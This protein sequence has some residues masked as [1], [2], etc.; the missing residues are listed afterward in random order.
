VHKKKREL[1][2]PLFV[3]RTAVNYGVVILI[4]VIFITPST[5]VLPVSNFKFLPVPLLACV[6]EYVTDFGV[7][8]R[9]SVFAQGSLPEGAPFPFKRIWPVP[10]VTD[11]IKVMV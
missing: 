10:L 8:L 7:S 11:A 6:H 4:P 3:N 9:L 2:P 5:A 1:A